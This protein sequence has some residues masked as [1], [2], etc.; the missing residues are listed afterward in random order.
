MA[1]DGRFVVVWQSMGQDGDRAGVFAQLFGAD[2]TAVGGEFQVN[3]HTTG[4]QH[5]SGVA[6][7]R[8]GQFIVT[9]SGDYPDLSGPKAYARLFDA[10]GVSM[11]QEFRVSAETGWMQ[12]GPRAAFTGKG[13]FVVTWTA[14]KDGY[15]IRAQRHRS[16]DPIFR[17]GF[18]SGGSSRR[19]GTGLRP[20][21]D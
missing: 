5:A 18:E 20:R 19:P 6:M 13:T 17:D 21:S 12:R 1:P 2:G 15:D 8:E 16:L 7:N 3:A 9:W 10:A 14:R 4:F 11:S